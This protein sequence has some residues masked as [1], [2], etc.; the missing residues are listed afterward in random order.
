MGS[1]ATM[2]S[3]AVLL[4]SEMVSA[5]QQ[6]T[7]ESRLEAL[8]LATAET[9]LDPNHGGDATSRIEAYTERLAA[10]VRKGVEKLAVAPRPRRPHVSLGDNL[11]AWLADDPR[12]KLCIV[13]EDH[14]DFGTVLMLSWVVEGRPTRH[15]SQFCATR[16]GALESLNRDVLEPAGFPAVRYSK[17][18]DLLPPKKGKRDGGERS[19]ESPAST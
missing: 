5:L 1:E 13:V 8:A 10:T 18:L 2:R 7:P 12:G 14:G 3:P 17:K 19:G 15:D 9:L 4:A 16:K 6:L 11:K